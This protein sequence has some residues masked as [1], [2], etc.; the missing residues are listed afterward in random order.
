MFYLP[1]L[2]GTAWRQQSPFVAFG[3]TELSGNSFKRHLKHVISFHTNT[4]TDMFQYSRQQLAIIKMNKLG[5]YNLLTAHRSPH[6][7]QHHLLQIRHMRM[8]K[9]LLLA[10]LKAFIRQPPPR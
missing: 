10:I 1:N 4:V 5:P 9:I 2:G 8:R 7:H 6:K 3:A